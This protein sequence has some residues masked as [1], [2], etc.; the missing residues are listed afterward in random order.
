V[1]NALELLVVDP[2]LTRLADRSQLALAELSKSPDQQEL[3][4]LDKLLET[5]EA[6]PQMSSFGEFF[7]GT[8]FGELFETVETGGLRWQ[9]LGFSAEELQ[10]EFEGAWRGLLREQG[11]AAQAAKSQNAGWSPEDIEKIRFLKQIDTSIR[12][13]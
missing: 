11:L 6:H 10:A 9:A 5:L 3:R 4:A 13:K 12:S 8:E 2:S 7:R 1:R